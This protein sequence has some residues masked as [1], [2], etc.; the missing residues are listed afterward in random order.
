M[1]S[2]LSN[3]LCDVVPPSQVSLSGLLLCILGLLLSSFATNIPVLFITYGVCFGIG[4]SF[5]YFPTV[6]ALKI[7]FKRYL[8]LANGISAS[9]SGL[10]TLLFGPLIEYSVDKVGLRWMFRLCAAIAAV[11]IL[12]HIIFIYIEKKFQS[13][14]E[15]FEKQPPFLKQLQGALCREKVCFDQHYQIMVAS[16]AIF[17]FGYFVPY[18]HLVCIFL[19]S[20]KRFLILSGLSYDFLL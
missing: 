16:M 19:S 20:Q 2:P 18:V 1:F 14:V 6:L 8:N 12:M 4:A 11:L 3:F 5:T 10:G 17:L 13:T 7:Y 15:A 9:G